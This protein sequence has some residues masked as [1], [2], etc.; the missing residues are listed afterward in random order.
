[1]LGCVYIEMPKEKRGVKK[2]AQSF[3]VDQEGRALRVQY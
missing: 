2:V 3:V 1:M